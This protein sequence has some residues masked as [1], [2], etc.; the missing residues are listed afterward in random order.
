MVR[1]LVPTRN[2]P[3]GVASLLRYIEKFHPENPVLLADGSDPE[4]QEQVAAICRSYAGRIQVDFR[5]Y[6]ASITLFK[7]LVDVLK[8]IDDETLAMGADDDYPLLEVYAQAD[9]HLRSDPSLNS[10]VPADIAIRH[11]EG[12]RMAARLSYSRSILNES[13]TER[14]KLFA[15]RSFATSY[16][17]ARRHVLLERYASLANYYCAGFIDF[18][19]GLL[20]AVQGRVLAWDQIGC[21]RTYVEG[22]GHLRPVEPLIFVRRS[23]QVLR[24]RDDIAQRLAVC[25]DKKVAMSIA[26]DLVECRI[27][28]LIGPKHRW[29]S[30][31]Q[32]TIL[33][34]DPTIMRQAHLLADVFTSETDVRRKLLSRLRYVVDEMPPATFGGTEMPSM[35]YE[36]L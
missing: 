24:F 28:E 1:L 3:E 10:V 21:I 9:A 5:P 30:Q 29:Q 34:D 27:L 35:N 31:A 36:I 6:S 14:A 11:I 17:V 20:D 25:T 33:N 32:K 13:A 16:G 4:K 23:E 12:G 15:A 7:R 26:N 8:C 19:I 22:D 2:R 18:Q